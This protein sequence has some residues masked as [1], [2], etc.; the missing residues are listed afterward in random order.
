[1]PLG[2]PASHMG[3]PGL[4]PPT[5]SPF[6]LPAKAHSGSGDGSRPP[7]GHPW[8]PASAWPWLLQVS[9]ECIGTQEHSV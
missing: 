1:M 2:I 5:P 6:Q 9:G 3:V 8:L 7:T 4:A